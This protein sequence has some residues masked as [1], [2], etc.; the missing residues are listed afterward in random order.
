MS[1]KPSNKTTKE[2]NAELYALR[3][4]LNLRRAEASRKRG[5][6]ERADGYLH[7]GELDA[8]TAKKW[9]DNSE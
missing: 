2:A 5:N 1:R 4:L 9:A 7:R 3:S 8:E 6:Q